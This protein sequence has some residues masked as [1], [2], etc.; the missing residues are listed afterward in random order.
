MVSSDSGLEIANREHADDR[1]QA[2]W[3][4]SELY[5]LQSAIRISLSQGA[6]WLVSRI[7]PGGPVIGEKNLNYVYK[8]V[9]GM[10]D[11][12]VDPTIL[13]RIFRWIEGSL[14]NNGDFYFDEEPVELRNALRVYRPLTFLKVAAWMNHPLAHDERVISRI[15]DYQ[16]ESGGVYDYIGELPGRVENELTRYTN[17]NTSFFGHLMVALDLKEPAILAGDWLRRFVE[18]NLKSMH[19]EGI[20]YTRTT[21]EGTLITDIDKHDALIHA[22]NLVDRKQEFWQIGT[23]MAYL[24]LLY[25]VMR[26][27]WGYTDSD[28]KPY[29]DAALAFNEFEASMPHYTYM[30]PSKCKVAWGAGELLRVLVKHSKGTQDQIDK[31]YAAARN[32]V[33]TTFI[34]NQLPNGGWCGEHYVTSKKDFEYRF[35]YKPIKGTVNVPPAPLP[36]TTAGFISGE[37][38]A[39]EF[40]GEMKSA[41][42]GISALIAVSAKLLEEA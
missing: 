17:L 30:W 7:H 29:L 42:R 13:A 11:A 22:V 4:L 1:K 27:R 21:I 19:S 36:G 16:H 8:G 28:A 10:H 26:E 37:E 18:S 14:R 39:G 5:H 9:W 34:D 35:E 2:E 15:L 32:T 20:V 38:I 6:G 24:A 33:V 23:T 25:D 31:A 41:E 12:G 40:L 3:M